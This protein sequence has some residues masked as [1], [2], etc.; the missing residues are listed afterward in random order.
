[1]RYRFGGFILDP[2]SRRLRA[3]ATEIALTPKAFDT[4]VALVANAGRTLAKE[5]L[6]RLVWKDVFVEEGG[7][8]RNISVLRKALGEAQGTAQFIRT[9][10]GRGYCFIAPV[11]VETDEAP[12]IPV[13]SPD[14]RTLAVLPFKFIGAPPSGDSR[15]VTDATSFC[16]GMAD[17]LITKLCNVRQIA[18]RSTGTVRHLIGTNWSA[19][20]A[21]KALRVEAIVEASLQI[22][23]ERLRV[24]VQ[25]VDVA[26]DRPLWAE[27][28]DDVTGDWFVVQDRISERVAQALIGRLTPVESERLRQHPT[29]NPDAHLVYLRGRFH[30]GKRTP[31]DIR[32]GLKCFEEAIRLDPRY[33]CAYAGL[34]D[35]YALLSYYSEL[36]AHEG[37]A[38]A[39][40][41]AR[42][43]LGID[44]EIAESHTT[45]AYIAMSYD[46]DWA[47]AERCF[48]RA[49]E[50]NP[51]YTPAAYWYVHFLA[52][53]GR[54]DESIALAERTA[55]LDPVSAIIG[56]N[57]GWAY[58][59]A[60][61]TAEALVRFEAVLELD[62]GF[63][64]TYNFLKECYLGLGRPDDALAAAHKCLAL[65][66]DSL[67]PRLWLAHA[68]AVTGDRP[69]ALRLV[70]ET[71][72]AT[73]GVSAPDYDVALVYA[74]LGDAD[75]A[76]DW[77][78]R[79]F[80]ARSRSLVFL[81]VEPDFQP[82]R[83]DPRFHSL[84]ARLN[85]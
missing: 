7:L 57:L 22:V 25:L 43:A 44:P 68:L 53:R 83:H 8:A 84:A 6:L 40:T 82:L 66:K 14:T 24:T 61:R 60:G 12:K 48:L 85:L 54:F 70:G 35:A 27:K 72:A 17:A 13:E 67:L 37:I 81:A 62:A 26:A 75:R 80:T 78:E 55:R 65:G 63:Y 49:F 11:M 31:E 47:E 77:L 5:E 36:P 74:A 45:L 59:T 29:E 21:G 32:A 76:F 38:K 23:G 1:M 79:A 33:A 58:L 28:F 9:V 18:V 50:R 2:E 73:S 19:A 30:V 39:K 52:A 34:A 10:A 15:F 4:L 56:T 16:L 69:A 41:F 20:E 46:W 51:N 42:C 71:L 64:L 3:G